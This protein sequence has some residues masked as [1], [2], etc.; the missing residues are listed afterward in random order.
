[1][2]TELMTPACRSRLHLSAS[3]TVITRAL[4]LGFPWCDGDLNIG[5]LLFQLWTTFSRYGYKTEM[6]NLNYGQHTSRLLL[7]PPSLYTMRMRTTQSSGNPTWG[8]PRITLLLLCLA[9]VNHEVQRQRLSLANFFSYHFNT[10]ALDSQVI[11]LYSSSSVILL[12]FSIPFFTRV[13]FST[14][15]DQI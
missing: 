9:L 14:I 3:K 8:Q 15:V 12:Y 10:S 7:D 2:S 1:M 5:T 13:T 6:D 11:N 4:F